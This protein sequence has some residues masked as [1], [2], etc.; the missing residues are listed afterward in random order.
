[1]IEVFNLEGQRT[2]CMIHLELT[3]GDLSKTSIFH[4][5]DSK[6][7]C[8]LLLGRRWLHDRGVVAS[9]LHQCFKYR[10]DREKKI[11]GDVKPFTKAEPIS[12][13]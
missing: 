3:I 2:I 4:V 9:T 12:Q 1:M 11:N 6:N 10:R 5:I 7:L 13:I 8:Q